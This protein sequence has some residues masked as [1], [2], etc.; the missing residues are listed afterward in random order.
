MQELAKGEKS[1]AAKVARIAV[2]GSRG[3]GKSSSAEMPEGTRSRATSGGMVATTC[4]S[5]SIRPSNA[6]YRTVS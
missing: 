1:G 4:E 5:A 6:L 2:R 3:G